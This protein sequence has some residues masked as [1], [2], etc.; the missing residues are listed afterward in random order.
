MGYKTKQ[1]KL[2]EKDFAPYVHNQ[3][4]C[5][6]CLGVTRSKDC[7]WCEENFKPST[8]REDYCSQKCREFGNRAGRSERFNY[9]TK[10]VWNK[11]K[12]VNEC[13]ICGSEG[14]SMNGKPESEKLCL[15]HK[16]GTDFVR[17][18]LCHN[19]NRALGLFQ[20]NPELLRKAANYLEGA[21]TIL[22]GVGPSGSEAHD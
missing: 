17:G 3:L 10:E 9:F 12:E 19:C 7:S 11:F 15:D 14:F 4:T 18:K 1:C 20:D 21:E 6:D 5:D 16:H 8:I 2:C 22:N 13:Q